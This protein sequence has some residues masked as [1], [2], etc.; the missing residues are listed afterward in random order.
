[1]PT[2]RTVLAGAGAV[3]LAPWLPVSASAAPPEDAIGMITD[4]VS[5]SIC[6]NSD[7]ADASFGFGEP[8]FHEWSLKSDLRASVLETL[9]GLFEGLEEPPLQPNGRLTIE[10]QYRVADR[11]PFEPILGTPEFWKALGRCIPAH[12]R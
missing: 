8:L 2:R 12:L 10:A 7:R 9:D 4:V 3:V 6:R 1:M 5:E 11:L